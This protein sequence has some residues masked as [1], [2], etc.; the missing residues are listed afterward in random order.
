MEN[1]SNENGEL[2]GLLRVYQKHGTLGNKY[3]REWRM[4]SNIRILLE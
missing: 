1:M 4:C 3:I 2:C